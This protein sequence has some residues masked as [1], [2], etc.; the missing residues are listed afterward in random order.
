MEIVQL[1]L[2]LSATADRIRQPKF[3][4]VRK[5]YDP[6]QVLEYLSKVADRVQAL[7]DQARALDSQ[8]K[9]AVKERDEAL[10]IMST[11]VEKSNPSENVSTRVAELVAGID[12]DVERIRGEAKAEAEQVVLDA[13]A[14]AARIEAKAN[15][16]QTVAAQALGKARAEARQAAAVDRA[17]Q[18]SVRSGLRDTCSQVLRVIAYLEALESDGDKRPIV[19][20]DSEDGATVGSVTGLAPLPHVPK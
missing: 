8:L 14:E 1:N 4:T 17:R 11:P 10:A 20:E 12:A 6:N 9:D 5:G 16:M 3:N 19:L 18:E 7:E 13:K 15:E 2:A